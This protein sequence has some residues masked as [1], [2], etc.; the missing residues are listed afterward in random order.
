MRTP[1]LGKLP[2]RFSFI[3]NRYSDQR[4]SKCP[5][6]GKHTH[7]R[8]FPLLIHIDGCGLLTLG[9]SGPYCTSCE[10]LIIHQDEL[11]GELSRGNSKITE[12]ATIAKYMVLGTVDA[13]VWRRGLKGSE[14]SMQE[15][16][17]CTSDFKE[18]LDLE[19]RPGGWFPPSKR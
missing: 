14:M 5:E 19:Y 11:E 2:P 17:R 16:L 18:V 3:L 8:K 7:R 12:A 4:L 15:L 1:K 6:C 9:K 10:L 13:G